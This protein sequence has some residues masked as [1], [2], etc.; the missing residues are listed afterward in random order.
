M[1]QEIMEGS[2]MESNELYNQFSIDSNSVG[3][4]DYSSCFLPD[5][6]YESEVEN[7]KTQEKISY[8][9]SPQIEKIKVLIDE[10][11]QKRVRNIGRIKKNNT[12][13]TR[14][15]PQRGELLILKLNPS[16]KL[17]IGTYIGLVSYQGEQLPAFKVLSK[18]GI[19]ES[20][21]IKA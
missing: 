4:G 8:S 16:N 1:I 12:R 9:N 20:M 14:F 15:D 6:H 11:F 3:S 10:G 7:E 5:D 21:E 19:Y 17:V 2:K 18:N 13:A